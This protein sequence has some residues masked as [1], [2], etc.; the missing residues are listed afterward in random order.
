MLPA[1]VIRH[2]KHSGFSPGWGCSGS[3]ECLGAS[4]EPYGSNSTHE[5][6]GS[7]LSSALLCLCGFF[8]FRKRIRDTPGKPGP[9]TASQAFF[10]LHSRAIFPGSKPALTSFWRG[11]T[12]GSHRRTSRAGAGGKGLA[13]ST[14]QKAP[15]NPC[16]PP[17]WPQPWER[18]RNLVGREEKLG[19][20][21]LNTSP[22]FCIVSSQSVTKWRLHLS[23]KK[24]ENNR[25][26]IKRKKRQN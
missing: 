13:E 20:Q 10:Q 11:S 4:P 15:A 9:C 21:C 26:K 2:L 8:C 22:Q 18:G 23:K 25:K 6:L 7:T 24:K 16:R 17:A 19:K 14:P 1:K 12:C 3:L 5:V